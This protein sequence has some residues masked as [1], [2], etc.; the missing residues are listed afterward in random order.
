MNGKNL[1]GG[2][3]AAVSDETMTRTDGH[4]TVASAPIRSQ[5]KH[6]KHKTTKSIT[7]T[8]ILVLYYSMYG[9][10]E[11]MAGSIAEGARTVEGAEV[12]IKRVPELMSPER[13]E[14]WREARPDG[15]HRCTG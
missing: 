12:T 5:L 15:A 11:T 9:H 13:A 2:D 3:A 10:I 4:K 14:T 6:C 7:M 8:K 1:S